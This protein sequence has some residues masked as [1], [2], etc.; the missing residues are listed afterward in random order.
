MD[1]HGAINMN[2]AQHIVH[3]PGPVGVRHVVSP[4]REVAGTPPPLPGPNFHLST[5]TKGGALNQKLS[6]FV[7]RGS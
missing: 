6:V 1:P 4:G 2:R 5:Q 3:K 7:Y